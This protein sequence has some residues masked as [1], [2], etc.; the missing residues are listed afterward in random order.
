MIRFLIIS[1]NKFQT[2]S[3]P[4]KEQGMWKIDFILPVVIVM[5]YKPRRKL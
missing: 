3:V 2:L 1:G 5:G 4:K